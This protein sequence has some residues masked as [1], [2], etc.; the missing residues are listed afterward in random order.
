ML[1]LFGTLNLGTRSLQVQQQGVEVAGHNLANVN[2]PAYSRQRLSIVTSSTIPTAIGPQGTGADV[3]A[4]RQLRSGILD[5]QIQGETSV[6]GF[7]DAQQRALELGESILGQSLDR[8]ATGTSATQSGLAEGLNSMFN[9]FQSLST[10]P[11]SITERQSALIQA[12]NLANQFNQ[13]DSRL[14]TLDSTL[15]ATI[16]DDVTK[17]N[18]LLGIIANYN[19]QI[20]T[21]EAGT[22]GAA[23][24]LRDLR[25]QRIEELAELVNLQT[26]DQATGGVDISIAGTDVVV[27]PELQDTLEVYDAGDGQLLVR[28]QTEG[29]PLALTGG[30]IQ[31]TI[32][33]RDGA[34]ANLRADL[35]TL[36]SQ[37]ITQVNAIHRDGFGLTG[38]TGTDFFTGTNAADIAVNQTILDDPSLL[39]ASGVSGAVGDN[40]VALSLAQLAND[41]QAALNNQT[42]SQS[43]SQTVSAIGQ[44]VWSVNA[45]LSD[46]QVVQKMLVRQRDSTS[47]VSLDEEMTDLIKY[48]QA[49]QASAR[50]IT[51]IDQMLD[52]V[53]NLK[54]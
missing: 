14:D 35:N 26:A 48:Q 8:A 51:T 2:N 32:D 30:T 7:Y 42:F 21:T 36:A 20:I 41:S 6:Q 9:A 49:Y 40:Q 37:L 47:G 39:Q 22:P 28:T 15:N 38:T 3:A 50:L 23:N 27:G 11:T 52:T 4:I 33:A 12:Q 10:D 53:V 13:I 44:S 17:A 43:Y 34:L 25:Q 45:A 29:T 31:G 46:Q 5:Q 18:D 19:K 54:R 24:D 1:G 16:T